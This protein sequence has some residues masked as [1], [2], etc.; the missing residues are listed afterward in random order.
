MIEYDALDCDY[1]HDTCSMFVNGMYKYEATIKIFDEHR[2]Q[3][4][5]DALE[6]LFKC[7]EYQDAPCK[8]EQWM[9]DCRKKRAEDAIL[10]GTIEI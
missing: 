8:S 2:K 6:L 10:K 9:V 7:V 1:A 4:L 5:K 3:V